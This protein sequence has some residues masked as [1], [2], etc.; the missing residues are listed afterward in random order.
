[1]NEWII[2]IISE[3][4]DYWHW[5]SIQTCECI[6]RQ[7]FVQFVQRSWPSSTTAATPHPSKKPS[8]T[9]T[10]PNQ[11]S[12]WQRKDT[13][14]AQVSKDMPGQWPK[15]VLLIRDCLRRMNDTLEKWESLLVTVPS[16][17]SNRSWSLTSLG[18]FACLLRSDIA[19]PLAK[20]KKELSTSSL[21]HNGGRYRWGWM[22]L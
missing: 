12:T 20:T 15:S 14:L 19:E 21:W 4:W 11:C 18:T 5:A 2:I 6:R 8:W 7:P 1:M 17:N 9:Y 13:S 16:W 3:Y 22:D 10:M